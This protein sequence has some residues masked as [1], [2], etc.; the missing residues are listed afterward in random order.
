M[1]KSSTPDGLSPSAA[2][3][4][5]GQ[6]GRRALSSLTRLGSA[7]AQSA[8]QSIS[9]EQ[10]EELDSVFKQ[11]PDLFRDQSQ[12]PPDWSE[13]NAP[14]TEG[15]IRT[16]LIRDQRSTPVLKGYLLS[17]PRL[18]LCAVA[19]RLGDA[20]RQIRQQ[21]YQVIVLAIG[22]HVLDM[23]CLLDLMNSSNPRSKAVAVLDD[24]A[25]E[26]LNQMIHP[27]VLGYVAAQDADK[28]LADAVIDVSQG[29]FTAS[30]R[31]SQV[32][33]RL[34]SNYLAERAPAT[35]ASNSVR[36]TVLAN[37]G[38]D[39]THQSDFG[40]SN[41]ASSQMHS[42]FLPSIQ[43]SG[44]NDASG[45]SPRTKIS[46]ALLSER[47]RG[48]L[49]LVAGGLSSADIGQQLAISVPTVNTHIRSIFSKLDVHTRAQAIHV[50]I[51]QG[52]IEVQ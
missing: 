44:F 25:M 17:D 9:S 30:P 10:R 15:T 3:R 12:M 35:S 45:F 36:T 39:T 6:I 27:K 8:K 51:T 21:N 13:M 4:Q 49:S 48:I 14:K 40:M 7:S 26:Q 18:H 29:R 46:T 24:Q 47:E 33:M 23:V 37:T 20:C 5:A 16:L 11:H 50:G 22:E 43:H 52:I 41:F 28:H 38:Y 34:T 1:N 42:S 2:L 31:T 32:V 19:E